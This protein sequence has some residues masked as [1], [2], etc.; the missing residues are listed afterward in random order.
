MAASIDSV[1][2]AVRATLHTLSREDQ[3]LFLE[4]KNSYLARRVGDSPLLDQL[5]CLRVVMTRLSEG[6]ATA[7]ARFEEGI[8]AKTGNASQAFDCAAWAR[9]P[10]PVSCAPWARG[11]LLSILP[12]K[13]RWVS[14]S[15]VSLISSP[16]YSGGILIVFSR[17]S[18]L[19]IFP[20]S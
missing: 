14:S 1:S 17:F 16:R 8:E 7:L 12:S 15:M 19:Y 6:Y 18:F 10:T 3:S 2:E 5:C 13:F 4:E 9:A 11:F 20:I